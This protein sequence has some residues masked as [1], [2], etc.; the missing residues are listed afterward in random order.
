MEGEKKGGSEER[1]WQ[2]NERTTHSE[3]SVEN[4]PMYIYYTH[5][6][7]SGN[8]PMFYTCSFLQV[9]V[10]VSDSFCYCQNEISSKRIR[11]LANL[12]IVRPF[13]HTTVTRK[14]G[15]Q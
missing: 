14:K 2:A 4:Q 11:L 5:K 12:F 13:K 3:F 15:G 9:Y 6:S 8:T 7:L 10:V 1:E